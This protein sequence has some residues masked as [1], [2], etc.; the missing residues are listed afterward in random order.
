[1]E[2]Y[3]IILI[4]RGDSEFE[5]EMLAGDC[6]SHLR[7]KVCVLDPART[8]EQDFTFRYVA[9]PQAEPTYTKQ[10]L[11][12]AIGMA[13][14]HAEK[15]RFGLL[16]EAEVKVKNIIDVSYL[17]RKLGLDVW[18]PPEALEDGEH[19]EMPPSYAPIEA[20]TEGLDTFLDADQISDLEENG[21]DRV[22]DSVE[23]RYEIKL[24]RK[25]IKSDLEALQC[26]AREYYEIR[27]RCALPG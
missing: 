1:M 25:Q 26:Y 10:D 12:M 13:L 3:A 6:Q 27:R 8:D 14:E 15:S 18:T 5:K 20:G 24:D 7:G 22:L 19:M 11:D 4:P 2:R 23:S 16:I 21:L 17:Q 9:R